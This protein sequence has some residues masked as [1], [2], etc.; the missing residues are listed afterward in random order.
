VEK[1][2]LVNKNKIKI[3]KNTDEIINQLAN[4]K[5]H[6]YVFLLSNIYCNNYYVYNS[7]YV[8]NLYDIRII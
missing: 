4:D 8:L 7:I 3:V 1:D 5:F 6:T 2:I